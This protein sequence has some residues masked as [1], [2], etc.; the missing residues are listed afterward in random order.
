MATIPSIAMI[1]S[2]YNVN[3]VYSVLP[4]DGSGHLD[5]F[6]RTS[7]ATR[8]NPSGLIETMATGVPR[9]DYSD[10]TCPSLLLEPA[11]TNE[12]QYS[13]DFTSSTWTKSNVSI[14]TVSSIISPDGT[15]NAYDVLN[16]SA[17]AC[18]IYD[19]EIGVSTS[20]S[21]FSVFVKY[22]DLQYISLR[23]DG[24]GDNALFDIINGTI[25]GSDADVTP[26]IKDY[27]NG[28]FRCSITH[29]NLLVVGNAVIQFNE[30]GVLNSNAMTVI[31]GG[32]YLWGAQYE[33]LSYATSL[34]PTA[35]TIISRTQDSASKS[36]ISS[37]INSTQGVFYAEISALVNTD[38]N[39]RTISLSENAANRVEL[40]LS[41]NGLIQGRFDN[42]SND[43]TLSKSGLNVSDKNKIALLW[44][45]GKCAL[46]VNGI[47]EQENLT[48]NTFAL[49]SLPN[50]YFNSSF[51]GGS[52]YFYGNVK[53][54]RVYNTALTD[55]ELT[56]LTTL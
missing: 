52:S 18:V 45:S 21:T 31:G 3:K 50:I 15:A 29:T 20:D 38:I 43:I 55:A 8:V 40:I 23:I 54:L 36:G 6:A 27:S 7:T 49:N 22:K 30:T 39:N 12:L 2:G 10:G 48:F 42:A 51:L 16:S 17:G 1:P 56:T 4:T 14:P 24:S 37:L 26:I 44:K 34:I 11:S 32:Y 5:N 46:W 9:L 41:K 19:N 33:V 47:K 25:I 13:H 53:D 35:G 28:W